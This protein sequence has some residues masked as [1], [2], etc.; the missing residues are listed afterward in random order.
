MKQTT[1]PLLNA[2]QLVQLSAHSAVHVKTISK[3]YRGEP[4]R[5]NVAH[6]VLQSA[7]AL[8]LPEPLD[9]VIARGGKQP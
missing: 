8:S 6:R 5:S 4:V 1:I 7:I 3:L 9:V 2:H